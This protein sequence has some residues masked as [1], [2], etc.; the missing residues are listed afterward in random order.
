VDL[1]LTGEQQMLRD[2]LRKL[3][4]DQ[5]PITV[6]RQME[7]DPIGYPEGLWKGLAEM[8]LP[9]L[10]L[11]EEHGGSG[12]GSLEL[13][14]VF[15]ELGR[16]LC[17]TPL[18]ETAVIGGG[19]IALA[20]SAEQKN[21]WLPRIA[22]GDAVL[23]PAFL[24][25]DSSYKA[26]GIQLKAERGADGYTLNGCKFFV[27]FAAAADRL[28]TLVR[29]GSGDE[30]IDILLVDPK[31][32]GVTLTKTDSHALDPRYLVTF[33]DVCVPLTDRIGGDGTGWASWTTVRFDLLLA[34]SAW[35]VGCGTRD[36]E[37]TTEYAKERVQ[38][39]RVIGSFQAIA[40]QLAD[41]LTGLNGAR[42]IT[43]KAAWAKDKG[44]A[45]H[46]RLAATAFLR[47]SEA[48]RFATRTGQQVFGGIG[49]TNDLDVQ[50]FF[51]RA[52]QH[53]YAWVDMRTLEDFIAAELID[54]EN[55]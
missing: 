11:A 20:G 55:K 16:A 22:T 48:A 4:A 2:A 54:G 27:G 50:L 37:L 14:V 28:I 43:W 17:P 18:L 1:E 15:E 47:A 49:F 53:M 31:A 33:E 32:K 24:E 45:E 39:D 26:G 44:R 52:K 38:F 12:L 41:S 5:C 46:Q 13:A 30:G 35:F 42:L 51:R 29:S 25:P 10:S 3:L 36:L 9:G 40:H 21:E 19:L 8:G 23:T 6:V 34:Q 7:N